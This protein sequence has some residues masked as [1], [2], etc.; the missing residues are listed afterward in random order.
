MGEVDLFTETERLVLRPFKRGDYHNWYQQF[1]NRLP[2]QY[3]YDDGRP[4][5]L[6]AFT[7]EWFTQWV[8][9]FD[10]SA[11]EDKMYNLGVLEKKMV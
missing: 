2:S 7:E 4:S 9:N 3:R 1:D 6:D 10:Q 5:N 11:K 8:S